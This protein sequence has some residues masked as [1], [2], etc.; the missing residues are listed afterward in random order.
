MYNIIILKNVRNLVFH[1]Y[2]GCFK[3]EAIYVS[4]SLCKISLWEI[5]PFIHSFISEI[6]NSVDSNQFFVLWVWLHWVNQSEINQNSIYTF[7]WSLYYFLGGKW[8]YNN[9]TSKHSDIK[10]I[11]L[12]TFSGKLLINKLYTTLFIAI[13]ALRISIPKT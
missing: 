8:W 6:D 2:Y 1:S 9:T 13:V 3:R 4:E 10:S 7:C 5:K 12:I 11:F